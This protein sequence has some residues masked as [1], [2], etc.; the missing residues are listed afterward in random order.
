MRPSQRVNYAERIERAVQLIEARG[1]AGEP[2]SLADLADAAALSEY[3]FHRVFRVMTGESPLDAVKRVRLGHSLAGLAAG[4][5]GE[6]TARSG[7]ATS[8]AYAR[9]LRSEAGA[10]PGELRDDAVRRAALADRLAR[11]T[12]RDDAPIQI[13]IESFEPLRLLTVRN[14]GAYE[15]LNAGYG[16]LFERVVD[17]VGMEAI[18][19]IYGLPHDDPRHAD[20]AACRFTCGLAT[21]GLG[22]A[23]GELEEL[24]L[25]AG[26]YAVM[27]HRGDFDLI[28]D[29]LDTLYAW[30]IEAGAPI[31]RTPLFIHYIDDPEEVAAQ[32]QRAVICLPL[33]PEGDL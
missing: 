23:D 21:G 10:S 15:E 5:I 20:P 22:R 28:H 29:R 25:A 33:E 3:H 13:A 19:G 4:G 12:A 26:R 14:V 11:P 31:A 2:P 6:A 18:A 9:A 32:D 1:A 24:T 27:V 8:Q 30:A 7:Y 16:R 17:Q